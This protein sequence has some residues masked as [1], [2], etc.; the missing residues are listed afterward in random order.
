M[1]LLAGSTLE[2]VKT[3]R[4]SG[5]LTISIGGVSGVAR[6]ILSLQGSATAPAVIRFK[7]DSLQD[8]GIGVITDANMYGGGQVVAKFARFE[9]LGSKNVPS[10]TTS[11]VEE[12]SFTISDSAF[13]RSG[14]VKTSNSLG[15]NA[16][17]ELQ[18]VI[19]KS[20]QGLFNLEVSGYNPLQRGN[21]IL[22]HSYFDREVRLYPANGFSIVE[23]IFLNGYQ[24]TE[25]HWLEF[26][27][28][29]VLQEGKALR[30]AGDVYDSY[31]LINNPAET[32]PH[33]IQTSY[34]SFDETIA[35]NIF[36]AIGPGGEGDGI[37]IGEPKAKTLVVVRDNIV[38]PNGGKDTSG[39]L[40]SG[41]GNKFVTLVIEHN[42]YFTG[43]QGVVIGE[44][45]PGRPGMISS[46]RSNLAWD[47]R[48]RGHLLIDIGRNDAVKDLVA[49]SAI[50]NNAAFRVKD[51][52][53]KF[54]YHQ[55][56]F[57]G[58]FAPE[59]EV[60]G[61]PSFVDNRRSIRSWAR[62]RGER[63]SVAGAIQLLREGVERGLDGGGVTPS[64]LISWVRA[65]FEPKNAAFLRA[66]HDG[67]T[68]GAVH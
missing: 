53:N 31:W 34:Y 61:D 51:G 39:T 16:T 40:L 22:S 67:V 24:V 13:I 33:F 7:K 25:G 11:A 60:R 21:R 12:R 68:I 3:R 56:E 48:A 8:H 62:S 50:S 38:L 55:L 63:E 45:Y 46:F 1:T 4:S 41:L 2:L 5:N 17:F 37:L 19:F 20:S 49:S 30:S 58:A 42:T 47:I 29:L 57:S 26:R 15:E 65:G 10:I 64:V 9:N 52:S 59:G 6:S 54:G 23:N 35:G 14:G 43:A 44:T 66:G 36:E 28:N 32:N 18:N 27:N